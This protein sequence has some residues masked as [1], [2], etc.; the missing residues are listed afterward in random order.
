MLDETTS[1]NDV[2]LLRLSDKVALKK[3]GFINAICL[4]DDERSVE[5]GTVCIAA[6]WGLQCKVIPMRNRRYVKVVRRMRRSQHFTMYP[7]LFRWLSLLFLSLS[8]F[9]S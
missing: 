4:P 7:C 5:K 6:G 9:L 1:V 2:A 8:L 3:D